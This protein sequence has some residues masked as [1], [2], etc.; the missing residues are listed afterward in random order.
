MAVLCSNCGKELVVGEAIAIIIV[1]NVEEN[2]E[3]GFSY[4]NDE[5][6]AIYCEECRNLLAV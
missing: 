3:N 4:G 6:E 2:N 5:E 1:A